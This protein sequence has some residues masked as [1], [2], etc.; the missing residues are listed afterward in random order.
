MRDRLSESAST[1]R[2]RLLPVAGRS[3]CSRNSVSPVCIALGAL[4]AALLIHPAPADLSAYKFTPISREEATERF[5]AWSPDGKNIAYTAEIHGIYQVFTKVPGAPDAAQL[6]HSTSSCNA[7]FWSPDG[8]TIYYNS[9]GDLWSVGASGGTPELVMEKAH[10]AGSSPDGKTLVYE[11]DGKTWVGSLKG[12][13]PRELGQVPFGDSSLMTFSPDGAR[14]AVITGQQLWILPWPSGTPRNV[15]VT[16]PGASWLPDSRHLLV[17]DDNNI[18]E[19]TLLDTNDASR[20]VIYRGMDAFMAPSVSPD[21][22]KIAYS[23]GPT[24][25]D[26]LEISLP[27][28]RVHHGGW[29]RQDV[30]WLP[31]WAPSGT[32]YLF[33][34]NLGAGAF[35]AIEDRSGTEGFSRRVAEAPQNSSVIGP[36]W[37]PDGARFLFTQNSSGRTQLTVARFIR[38]TV[39]RRL[40]TT[41]SPSWT[42]PPGRP[43]DN[44]SRSYVTKGGR[45]QQLMRDETGCGRDPG[46]SGECRS[47]RDQLFHD[48]MVSGGRR[49]QLTNRRTALSPPDPRPT[50]IAVPQT[51]LRRNLLAFAFSREG[52]QS[53]RRCP[54]HH[55]QGRAMAT[56]DLTSETGADKLLAPIDLPASTDSIAGFQP[57]SRWQALPHLHREMAVRYHGCSKAGIRRR[58]RGWIRL[59]RR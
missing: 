48:S 30:S 10:G 20:R 49:D 34:T 35:R 2:S 58:R 54:Q 37:A 41:V 3:N 50:V 14:L 38:G 53:L 26:I 21:G 22:K 52:S 36:K 47:G 32:H 59:L 45:N 24:E 8:A 17:R 16:G 40:P 31:D 19:L 44:G 46:G 18:I 56:I 27:D 12:A 23:A 5:P 13:T 25:W 29:R 42:P 7:P 9:H 57:S 39:F 4:L 43:T 51:N 28:A 1:A 15:G 55:G 33:S 6:T 11:R